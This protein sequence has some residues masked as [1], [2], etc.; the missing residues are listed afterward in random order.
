[1]KDLQIKAKALFTA[2]ALLLTLTFPVKADEAADFLSSLHEFRVSNFVALDAFYR[3]SS[4]GDTEALNEIVS[5]INTANSSMSTVAASTAQVLEATDIETLNQAF[6]KFKN[7]VR[8]N[9]NEVRQSGYPDLQLVSEMADQALS[10]NGKA[11]ELYALALESSLVSTDERVEAARRASV[12]MAQMMAKYSVRSNM[13]ASQTFQGS[14]DETPLD[15][16]AR[17]FEALLSQ[18]SSG[19]KDA[20]LNAALEGIKSKWLFIKGSYINY[21][22]NN[23]S[24]VI[25]RYSKG[26]LEDLA[27]TIDLLQQSA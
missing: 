26:I 7:L 6:D 14:S 5:A 13:A 8:L 25:D 22:E 9:I 3:F 27:A 1:M 17:E 15:E 4:D 12:T 19:P 20:S 23:V 24:F 16:K 21:N 10:L 18:L 2:F 11:S